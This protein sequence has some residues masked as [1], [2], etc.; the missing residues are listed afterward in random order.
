[1]KNN[2]CLELYIE[3]NN[4][5]TKIYKSIRDEEELEYKMQHINE[6]EALIIDVEYRDYTNFNYNK[7]IGDF[8][9]AC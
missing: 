8:I 6:N 9:I 1:M 3:F 5:N 7:Q 2:P 4:D